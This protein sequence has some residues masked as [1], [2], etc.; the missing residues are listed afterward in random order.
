[1][2]GHALTLGA[3]RH[4]HPGVASLIQVTGTAES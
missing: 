1:M 4:P 2:T 3:W